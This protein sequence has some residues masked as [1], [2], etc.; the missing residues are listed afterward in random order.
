MKQLII[1]KFIITCSFFSLL[2]CTGGEEQNNGSGFKNELAVPSPQQVQYQKKQMVAFAHFGVNT[3]TDREWGTGQEEPQMFNPKQ[4]DAEQW[5]KVLSE[6]GF[7]TLILTAKHHDGFCLWPSKFTE[8][9]VAN[10]PYKNGEGDI[11]KEV[12]E[13]CRKYGIDFGI[14]LSPWDMHEPSYGTPAYNRFY[15]NQL[16]ELLTNYGPIAEVWLDGA[17]GEDAKDMSYDFEGWRAKVRELQPNA[18]MF[19][20][21]GPDIRWIGNEHGFAGTTNWS[22][23]DRDSVTIG[24]PGQG[25]YLNSGQEGAPDWVTGECDVSIRPGWFYHPEENDEV[26]TVNELMEIYF[27]S[28]GRNCTLLLNIPPDKTGRF[29]EVDVERLHS[30]SARLDSIFDDDLALYATAMSSEALD[31]HS[32]SNVIDDNWNTYWQAKNS[33]GPS[34][35]NIKLPQPQ[36][37]NVISLQ[38]YI[39]LGQRV[40]SFRVEIKTAGSD[41]WKLAAKG[42]TV[43]HKRIVKLEQTEPGIS[44]LRV[45]FEDALAAPALSN[46]SLYH[47]D[48]DLLNSL[49]L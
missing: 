5:A 45:I 43:G 30:F 7:K 1:Y 23:I 49:N 24:K 9:D 20:D 11:V 48:E 29:H 38:E 8:H 25:A 46:L 21:A 15:E 28:V 6:T 39:S 47:T 42:T 17:K 22:T 32:A 2:A 34:T 19:S 31:G 40:S 26:K 18:L 41:T 35:L 13:A 16:E 4:F 36:Q 33:K 12:A 37:I 27:K 10:S 14:Y 3:Y 44:E